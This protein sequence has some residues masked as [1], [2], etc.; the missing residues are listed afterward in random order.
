MWLIPTLLPRFAVPGICVKK[1]RL[2]GS[3]DI[4]A[5]GGLLVCVLWLVMTS[6]W[7]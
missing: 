5:P 4:P 7:Q 1:Q 6:S 2:C 3:F